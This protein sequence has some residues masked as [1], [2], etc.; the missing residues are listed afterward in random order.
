MTLLRTRLARNVRR[1][2]KHCRRSIEDGARAVRESPLIEPQF[3]TVGQ[4]IADR[5]CIGGIP[6]DTPIALFL[7][8]S[9]RRAIHAG[10]AV[11][12]RPDPAPHAA[13][14]VAKVRPAIQ[15]L[16]T[17]TPCTICNQKCGRIFHLEKFCRNRR[18]SALTGCGGRLLPHPSS[19]ST[20]N[21][22]A[23]INPISVRTPWG[24][25]HPAGYTR[26]VHPL[27]AKVRIR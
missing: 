11:T 5:H 7:A 3:A 19:P 25:L 22:E 4:R 1:R 8:Q 21:R 26:A 20:V 10:S 18:H 16:M 13:Q 17:I 2:I 24:R 15:R 6:A 12:E 23:F 27:T 9:K 14:R